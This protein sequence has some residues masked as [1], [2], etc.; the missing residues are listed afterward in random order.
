HAFV[1]RGPGPAA[2]SRRRGVTLYQ[3]DR[4]T[5]VYPESVGQGAASLLPGQDRPAVLWTIDLDADGMPCRDPSLRRA[6]VRSR[7]ALSYPE[8]QAAVDAGSAEEPL[9]LLRRVGLLRQQRE[10]DRG[11]VSLQLATQK[12]VIADGHAN[13]EFDAAL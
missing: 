3:P 4:R 8:V 7:A 6:T 2:E 9:L 11:G 13:L 10:A 12:V 1:P 5:P